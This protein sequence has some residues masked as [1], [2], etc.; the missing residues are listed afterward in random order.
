[1]I[2]KGIVDFHAIIEVPKGEKHPHPRY[3]QL[4]D[5]ES[6]ARSDKE[7]K[8]VT[9]HR[10]F[11]QAG[12]PFVLPPGTPKDRV[13]ILQ[14]AMRRTFKDPEFHKEYKKTGDD[15]APLTGDALEKLIKG[16][17]RESEVVELFKKLFGADPLPAR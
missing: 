6:F 2:D 8:L 11:Q 3:A 13:E 7:R 4:P 1:L 12:A 9:M 10:T 16:L 15:S 5:I 17:P 14:E